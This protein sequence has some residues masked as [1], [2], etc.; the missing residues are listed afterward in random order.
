MAGIPGR[1]VYQEI[2]RP[3]HVVDADDLVPGQHP[4]LEVLDGAPP[5]PGQPDSDH[6]LDA[7]A[8]RDRIHVGMIANDDAFQA[9][10]PNPLETGRG[11]NSHAFCQVL[12]RD[13][14]ILPQLPQDRAIDSV[15]GG[16][17]AH[18]ANIIRL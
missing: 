2:V 5:V 1:D 8:E 7:D 16:F 9:E 6:R 11:R 4:R 12:V 17:G 3:R 18:S 14:G 15:Q 13:P 10:P